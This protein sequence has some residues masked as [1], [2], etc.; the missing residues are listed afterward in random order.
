MGLTLLGTTHL[1]LALQAVSVP[2]T[3]TVRDEENGR[4]LSGAVI[5]LAD[6]SQS[7]IADFDGRYQL[8]DVPAGPQLVTVRRI[9]YAPRTL[10]LLV[11]SQGA[12]EVNISLRAEP[13]RLEAIEVFGAIPV[14]GLEVADSTAYPDRSISLPAMQYSPL[15][16]ETDVLQATAGGEVALQPESPTG[17]HIRGGGPDQTAYLLDGIPVFSPYHVAGTFSAWNPDALARLDLF[18]A[19]LSPAF[20]DALS[21]V[22][23]A[24]TRMPGNRARSQGSVSSTQARGTLDGPIGGGGGGYLLSYRSTFTGLPFRRRDPTYLTGEGGDWLVKLALPVLRGRLELLGYGN[25]NETG[26]ATGMSSSG[27]P[28]TVPRRNGF[29]WNSRSL[30]LGWTRP[31]GGALLQLR[32]WNAR[33]DAGATWIGSET[34][35]DHLNHERND[36]GA[37]ATVELVGR[38]HRTAA[39][40]R[41]E[42]IRTRYELRPAS[43][44]GDSLVMAAETPVTSVFLEH[45]HTLF[46]R[47]EFTL[48]LADAVASGNHYLSPGGELRWQPWSDVTVSGSYARRHQFAQSLRNPESVVGNIFPADLFVAASP[49]SV[50]VA[51]SDVGT[52]GVEFRPREGVRLAAHAYTREF[53]G[54]ALVAAR[55]AGP[56]ARSQVT[57]GTGNARGLVVEAGTAGKRFGLVAK[58]ALQRVRMEFGDSSYVPDGSVTHTL[59]AGVIVFPSS[60]FAIRLGFNGLIGRRATAIVGDFEW[61]SCNL[62]DLG[63]EF[64]G[65]PARRAEPLGATPLPAYYRVDLGVRKEWRINVAGRRG[66]LAAFGTVTNLLGRTNVLTYTEDPA[67]GRRRPV[68]MRPLSPLVF[69]VDWRY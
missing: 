13:V 66:V 12:L 64:A 44:T 53:R 59:D 65:S 50:P 54:L 19:G 18:T 60:S 69:G 40:A 23:A 55:D 37:S 30:G 62:M 25:E 7:A 43:G 39:G 45:T 2:V 51:R 31:I 67:T 15:L 56:Y 22:V 10:H 9:G 4:P 21:G 35:T 41:L 6:L 48:S 32:A 49:S 29:A 27:D 8:H 20:P 26:A 52:L 14:P 46:A 34:Q 17:I 61:E 58:Y 3:G 68:E 57:E 24:S 5:V 38:N 11:P 28:A 42:Q 63:C 16:A 36:A 47:T 1:L 33:A